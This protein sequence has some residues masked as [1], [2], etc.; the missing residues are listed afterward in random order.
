LAVSP[1]CASG[2]Y[3][4][5]LSAYSYTISGA[6]YAPAPACTATPTATSQPAVVTQ[7]VTVCTP[8]LSCPAG[9]CLS[10]SQTT[11]MCVSQ[12]GTKTCPSEFPTRTIMAPSFDDTRGCGACSCG[13]TLTCDLTG[14]LLDNDSACSTG[15]IYEMTATTSC[16]AAPS[17]YPLNAVQ[18]Q[19]T[20]TGDGTCAPAGPSGATGGVVLHDATTLTVCCK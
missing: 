1:A 18:A 10:P 15:H 14:V 19:S 12:A 20:T 16:S 17:N 6:V 11:S 3:G 4:N 8:A 13:S 7:A 5:I 2:N 9:A